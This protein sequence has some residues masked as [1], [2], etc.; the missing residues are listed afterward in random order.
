MTIGIYCIENLANNKK[1]IGKSLNLDKRLTQ[2][3]SH[4]K[5][6]LHANKHLQNAWN[7]YGYSTFRFFILE[8]CEREL[9]S[10]KEVYYIKLFE[11]KKFGYNMTDGGDG[12]IGLS[13]TKEVRQKLSNYFKEN[14][15]RKKGEYSHSIDTKIKISNSLKGRKITEE[16]K[17]KMKETIKNRTEEEQAIINKKLSDSAKN[18][19]VSPELR[20]KM[21]KA[22]WGER[23]KN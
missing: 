16:A 14:P 8:E 3:K 9:L 5:R 10:E 18:R 19:T 12:T 11:T 22:R 6:N 21:N 1:Y 15:S 20:E 7:I 13:V 23:R 17:Q 2:H 4:L